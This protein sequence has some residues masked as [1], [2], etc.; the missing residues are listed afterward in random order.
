MITKAVFLTTL[1]SCS[2]SAKEPKLLFADDFER[3]ESQEETEEIGEGW[4]SGSDTRA[5]G[6]KQ[7]DLRDGHLHIYMH[8]VADHAVSVRHEAGFENGIVEARFNLEHADDQLGFNFADMTYKGVHA[9]HLFRVVLTN[10]SVTI[11][12]LKTGIMKKEIREMRKAGSLPPEIENTLKDKTKR[13][14]AK[15]K[16]GKWHAIVIKIEG[17]E[18][19]VTLNKRKVGSF[20][21][22]GIAHPEKGLLRLS[23]PREALVDD[24]K[25]YS[26]S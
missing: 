23:V 8:E 5:Q 26:A 10:N 24:L 19:T 1:I 15:I 14:P 12:D 21:S 7:V 17:D 2:L 3:N 6:N 9:G 4:T 16:N 25:I 13:F 22:P 18:I 20:S 11:T